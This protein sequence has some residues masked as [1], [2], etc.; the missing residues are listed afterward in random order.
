MARIGPSS[1][2]AR[3]ARLSSRAMGSDDTQPAAAAAS[4]AVDRR[5]GYARLIAF[6]VAVL[7]LLLLVYAI[8]TLRSSMGWG[9]DLEAYLAAAQRL[10]RGDSMYEQYSLDGPFSPGPYKLYLYSPPFAA[11]MMPF[12]MLSVDGAAMV[13]YVGRVVMLAIALVFVWR[14]FYSMRIPKKT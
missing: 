9:F 10:A 13:W 12:T 11:V 2:R 5:S 3:I 6:T 7:G 1:R 8:T 4:S 14:S